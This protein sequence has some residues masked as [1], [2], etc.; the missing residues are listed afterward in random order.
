MN[1]KEFKPYIFSGDIK[2]A[3]S[4]PF[5][6]ITQ[7]QENKL[8]SAKCN[9]TALSMPQSWSNGITPRKIME[10]WI[11]DKLIYEY[12]ENVIIILKQVFYINKEA[13]ARYGIISLVDINNN[14]STHENTFSKQVME[15]QTVM[16]DL[17]AQPEPIFIVIPDN[18]FDKMIKR[19]TANLEEKF[20]FEE[21]SGVENFVYFLDD[22]HKIERIKESLANVQGIVA[23]GHHRTQAIKNLQK[24]KG[25]SFWNYALAYTTSIYGNGLM[26]GGVDRLVYRLNFEANVSKIKNLFDVYTEKTMEED[27][28]IRIYSRGIFYI[29]IPKEYTIR[30][31]FG[32]AKPLSTEII[33]RILFEN[34]FG[35]EKSEIETKVSYIYNATDAINA[36]DRHE[37]EFAILIPSWQKDDFLNLTMENRIFPQKSTYFYPKIPSGIAVYRRP[38]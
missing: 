18:N 5:D 24:E 31:T 1:I 29:I 9:I 12:G 23:D 6:T 3:V 28:N 13:V 19:Y 22:Q 21:P 26:I 35:L 15:R 14:I 32:T 17:Q 38:S 27:N 10:K 8:R 16:D 36:V 33:N 11:K 2:D 25:D 7:E 20:K 34:A 37:C 30:E 4:P